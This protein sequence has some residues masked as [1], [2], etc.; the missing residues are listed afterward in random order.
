[1]GKKYGSKGYPQGNAAH[2]GSISLHF[3]A[4]S[5]FFYA[6]CHVWPVRLYHNFAHYLI[7]GTLFGEKVLNIKFVFVFATTFV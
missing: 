1:V 4:K 2:M 3:L 7:N 5:I 6:Y